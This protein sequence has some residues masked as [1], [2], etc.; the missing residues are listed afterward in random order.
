MCA[1][2]FEIVDAFIV[3]LHTHPFLISSEREGDAA[4]EEMLQLARAIVG[5]SIIQ[6]I[7]VVWTQTPIPASPTVFGSSKSVPCR[8]T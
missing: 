7:D 5:G 3:Y 2:R 4:A 6:R 8:G 1:K